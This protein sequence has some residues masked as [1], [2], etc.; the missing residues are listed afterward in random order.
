MNVMHP[1]VKN[2]TALCR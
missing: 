1:V 2:R